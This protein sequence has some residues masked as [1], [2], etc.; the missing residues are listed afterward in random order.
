MNESFDN[1]HNSPQEGLESQPER[2]EGPIE[3][4]E[5]NEERIDKIKLRKAIE[6]AQDGKTATARFE[7]QKE[8]GFEGMSESELRAEIHRAERAHR[9]KDVIRLEKILMDKERERVV[10]EDTNE[11][12][13]QAEASEA[14]KEVITEQQ[15]SGTAETGEPEVVES[16]VDTTDKQEA[17]K[18]SYAERL[19]ELAQE[20][21]PLGLAKVALRETLEELG[22]KESY[23]IKAGPFELLG[24]A[25]KLSVVKR[26]EDFKQGHPQVSADDQSLYLKGLIYKEVEENTGLERAELPE[27]PSS[28]EEVNEQEGGQLKNETAEDEKETMP[29]DASGPTEIVPERDE[30]EQVSGSTPEAQVNETADKEQLQNEQQEIYEMYLQYLAGN[31][32]LS[33]TMATLR[34]RVRT[35]FENDET[36]ETPDKL[37]EAMRMFDLHI[38]NLLKNDE[39]GKAAHTFVTTFLS[40]SADQDKN[41]PNDEKVMYKDALTILLDD[42]DLANLRNAA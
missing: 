7:E 1:A 38:E 30:V 35:A 8:S 10:Q 31:K 22:V 19:S 12:V 16:P 17:P 18:K 6:I 26:H 36:Y 3:A 23:Y 13:P 15:D 29:E 39:K 20:K 2:V 32:S 4:P 25:D 14:E 41:I 21:D 40:A 28:Q 9:E 33:K 27:E 24:A 42:R 34:N 11:D 5:F 37:A